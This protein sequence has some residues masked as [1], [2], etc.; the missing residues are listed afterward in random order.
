M[1]SPPSQRK[2]LG[3]SIMAVVITSLAMLF[4]APFLYTT[5][6]SILYMYNQTVNQTAMQISNNQQ[7]TPF[8]QGYKDPFISSVYPYIYDV[9]AFFYYI[10]TTPVAFYTLIAIDILLMAFDVIWLEAEGSE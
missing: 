7:L 2:V 1:Y 6:K 10:D 9:F 4:I 5:V 3:Y 8:S